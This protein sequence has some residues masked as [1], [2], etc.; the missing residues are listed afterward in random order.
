MAASEVKPVQL[1]FVHNQ[2]ETS[3]SFTVYLPCRVSC[4]VVQLSM[5]LYIH[6]QTHKV[7]YQT[8][9]HTC[10]CMHTH[11]HRDVHVVE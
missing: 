2:K 9:L 11:T 8:I 6:T 4:R 1:P 3:L 7:E 10:I 5:Y